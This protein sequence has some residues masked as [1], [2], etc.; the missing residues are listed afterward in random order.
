MGRFSLGKEARIAIVVP[1]VQERGVVLKITL[2][3][4]DGK[5][6]LH[7]E[8][9]NMEDVPKDPALRKHLQGLLYR[10]GEALTRAGT[11]SEPE[12]PESKEV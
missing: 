11:A 7:V 2:D 3:F 6:S 4:K 12:K 9:L 8:D 5:S 10:L 1:L